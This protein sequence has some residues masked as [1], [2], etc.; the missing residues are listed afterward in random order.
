MKDIINIGL[1]WKKPALTIT[2]DWSILIFL[3]L[4]ICLI[5]LLKKLNLFH[6]FSKKIFGTA[7]IEVEIGAGVKVKAKVDRSKEN[8]YIAHRILVE[9]ETRKAAIDIEPEK[10]VIEDLYNSWYNLFGVIR[11][12]MKNIPAKYLDEPGTQDLL[13]LSRDILNKGLRPHLTK[14]QA[15]FKRWYDTEKSA[16]GNKKKPPQEIQKE[17]DHYQEII[18]EMKIVNQI[19]KQYAD[20][21]RKIIWKQN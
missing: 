18:D 14:Y 15:A 8:I 7:D 1:D 4:I 19:L 6:W 21:L 3:F 13:N 9:L 5:F 10:D 2:S 12:E 17:Y 20:G 11:T 16:D